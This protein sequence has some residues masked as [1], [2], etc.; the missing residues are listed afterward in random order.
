[1]HT[2]ASNPGPI[3]EVPNGVDFPI[4]SVDTVQFVL[5]RPSIDPGVLYG[6]KIASGLKMSVQPSGFV[7]AVNEDS[8]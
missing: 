5:H 1:M 2:R 7:T 4:A 6:A 8:S 3:E